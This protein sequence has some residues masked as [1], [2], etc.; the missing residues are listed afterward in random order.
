MGTFSSLRGAN[1]MQ[2]ATELVTANH[3]ERLFGQL[4][5][6]GERVIG[7]E[8]EHQHA[9]DKGNTLSGFARLHHANRS[10]SWFVLRD[11]AVPMNTSA[12][13]SE[14]RILGCVDG[15]CDL[16]EN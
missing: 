7:S 9:I 16:S 11:L 2:I 12:G 13:V 14:D 1:V 5:E 15:L 6:L 4:H 8:N 3:F 10:L